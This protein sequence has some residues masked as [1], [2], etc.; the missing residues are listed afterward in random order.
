M[1]L[2]QMLLNNEDILIIHTNDNDRLVGDIQGAL[3]DYLYEQ[4]DQKEH[5]EYYE[6]ENKEMMK[7]I[8]K[9][10]KMLDNRKINYKRW[11]D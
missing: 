6:D 1:E 7:H 3:N 5:L 11:N 8:N 4:E 10:E 2:I 9:L